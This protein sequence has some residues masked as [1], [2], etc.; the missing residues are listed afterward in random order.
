[1]SQE[2]SEVRPDLPDLTIPAPLNQ[3]ADSS[4]TPK[5]KRNRR[6]N[7]E[8]EIYRASQGIEKSTSK[9]TN[10]EKEFKYWV[11]TARRL[12]ALKKN[13]NAHR[14]AA[15]PA[16]STSRTADSNPQFI[17]TDYQLICSYLEDPQHYTQIYGNGTRTSVGP[18]SLTKGAA[19]D[20]FAIYMNDQTNKRLHLDGKLLR[21]RIEAYKKRFTSAKHWADTTGAGIDI[22]DNGITIKAK[23]E[24]MCP[25]YERMDQIFGGKPNVTPAAQYESQGGMELYDQ[26]M[27]DDQLRSTELIC[28]NREVNE[29]QG[30]LSAQDQPEDQ[31]HIAAAGEETTMGGNAELPE[32]PNTRSTP[33]LQAET[34]LSVQS[35]PLPHPLSIQTGTNQ[36]RRTMAS[37][38]GNLQR[39]VALDEAE[40]AADEVEDPPMEPGPSQGRF[41]NQNADNQSVPGP[42]REPAGNQKGKSTVA[43]AFKSSADKKFSYLDKHMAMEERKFEW[44]K[45]KHSAEQNNSTKQADAKLRMAEKLM[46]EGRSAA[47]IEIIMRCAF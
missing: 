26:P 32:E 28:S 25:C 14:S 44:E 23:L 36:P 20:V 37:I 3:A 40:D 47:E 45:K 13:S 34:L 1:M 9:K 2:I 19:Y 24:S 12:A 41:P 46:S 5:P 17:A 18:Q 30:T 31:S 43:A 10:N 35:Q 33:A 4:T 38:L 11:P 22:C 16:T 29:N 6:T 39:S 27:D 15:K 8:M 7:A 21:Q 42:R